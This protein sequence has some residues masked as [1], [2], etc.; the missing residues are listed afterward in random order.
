MTSIQ[1]GIQTGIG[2]G[3]LTNPHSRHNR[4][5]P[6]RPQELREL[7]GSYGVVRSTESL[8]AINDVVREFHELGLQVWIADGGDGCLSWMLNKAAQQLCQSLDE[9]PSVM[10]LILPTNG[11]TV[12]FVAHRLGIRGS[13]T[14]VMERL[15]RRLSR[16]QDIPQVKLPTLKVKARFINAEGQEE[17]FERLVFAAAMA[18]FSSRFFNLLYAH[19]QRGPL[20]IAWV[21]ARCAVVAMGQLTR[22]PFL[23]PKSW[24]KEVGELWEPLNLEVEVD[25]QVLPYDCYTS[26]NAGAFSINLGGVFRLFPE[27]KNGHMHV[28][29]GKPSITN[30]A[31]RL[32]RLFSNAHLGIQ[33]LYDGPGQ[34]MR[35]KTKDK[36]FQAVFDGERWTNMLDIEVSMGPDLA[37]A[38]I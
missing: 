24:R 23:A 25:G 10:P 2:L 31:V 26:V 36:P 6:H 33:H 14:R 20:R 13:P 9:L 37:F 22:L 32:H 8:D 35:V 27:A 19:E 11:G 15:I 38:R 1:T 28:L 18:G 3:I 16:P 34:V 21:T 17:E 30:V 29:A 5:N 4:K 12:N 7:I